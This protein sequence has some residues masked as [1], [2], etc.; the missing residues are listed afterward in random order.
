MPPQ[1]DRAFGIVPVYKKPNGEFLFCLVQHADGHWGFPKGHKD[2][3]ES[4]EQTACRELREETGVEEIDIVPDR[5]FSEQ[6]SFERNGNR[7]DKTVTYFIGLVRVPATKTLDGFKKEILE[8]R[9][10]PYDEMKQTL[11]FPEGKEQMLTD[12]WEYLHERLE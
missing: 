4:D 1:E 3:G 9:W 7:Y 11:S 8:V 5:S 6:Y 10:L 12:V 2:A